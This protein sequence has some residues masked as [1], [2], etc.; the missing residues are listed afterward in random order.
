MLYCPRLH[1]LDQ[2]FRLVAE[3]VSFLFFVAAPFFMGYLRT[4]KGSNRTYFCLWFVDII[5][6]NRGLSIVGYAYY[7]SSLFFCWFLVG[8]AFSFLLVR[9]DCWGYVFYG[10]GVEPKSWWNPMKILV[11]LIL[12]EYLDLD[13]E[14]TKV[15]TD[16]RRS[17]SSSDLRKK[18]EDSFETIKTE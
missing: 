4:P 9:C 8:A 18:I 11:W 1:F 16:A 2:S 14:M 13:L 15:K 5:F 12:K 3:S 6:L 10:F 17:I 7:V